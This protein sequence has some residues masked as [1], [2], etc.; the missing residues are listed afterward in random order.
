[1]KITVGVDQEKKD[2]RDAVVQAVTDLDNII[3]NIDGATNAQVKAAIKTLAQHQ[4]KI[5]K[6]L[7]NIG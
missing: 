3:A 1:M 4:K 2:I 7:V 5:I 6:R